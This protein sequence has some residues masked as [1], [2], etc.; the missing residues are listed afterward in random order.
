MPAA[1]RNVCGRGSLYSAHGKLCHLDETAVSEFDQR[2][3]FDSY[4]FRAVR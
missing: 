1:Y 2:D 4:A 3:R